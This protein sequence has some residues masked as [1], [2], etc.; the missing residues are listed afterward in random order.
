MKHLRLLTAL[1]MLF[2][3][4][5][6]D[7]DAD[8]KVVQNAKE[9]MIRATRYFHDEVARHGGYVYHYSPDLKVRW[10]EGLATEDQIWVQPPGTPTVG[11]AYLEAYSATLDR[12]FLV[13]AKDA[14]E[15]LA[16]GQ[17]QSG[18]W[19]NCVDFNPAGERVYLYRNG[20]GRGRNNS[21]LDDGQT[22][23][24]LLFLIRMDGV[25]QFRDETIHDAAMVGLDAVL[26]A[27][28]P[29]GGFP[30]SWTEPVEDRPVLKAKYPDHDWRT[31][32]RIKNY[33]DMYTLNDNVCGYL[34]QTLIAAHETYRDERSL[35]ALRKLGDFLILAQM[36]EPQPGWA[37]QY[38]PDMEPIWARK[39]EPPGVSGDETQEAIETLLQIAK[40]TGDDRYLEPIP[41]ALDYLDRS[42]LPD[43]QL[44]R[45]Y[46]LK[47]NRPLYMKRS[48][49]TYSLT[50]DSSNLPSH[51]GWKTSAKID[52]LRQSYEQQRAHQLVA[53]PFDI[54]SLESRAEQIIKDLDRQGRWVTTASGERLV[55][56]PKI[57]AGDQ[58]ISSEVFSV[59]LITLSTYLKTMAAA[60][61]SR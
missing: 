23:S 35:Q 24:A 39:F 57:R 13:A 4:W 8:D 9:T 10:G 27:Q 58:Y 38:N 45:Y 50:Y 29:N 25:L 61:A 18:G 37:Q 54:E 2:M 5:G 15:A 42:V 14:A 11:M 40:Y 30:Q 7:A 17:L 16:Y 59:N 43:G 56:Q 26:N 49:G 36:P 55:G 22:Q 31:E 41:A 1:W 47:T 44:A 33:W 3:G 52:S 19:A 34:A 48:G 21:S 51:Y 12:E 32:G 53:E 28:F 6:I 60:L 46:E 20:K